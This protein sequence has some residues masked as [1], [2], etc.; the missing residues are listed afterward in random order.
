MQL[1][2]KATGGSFFEI[3]C[4][5]DGLEPDR[6]WEPAGPVWWPA[7]RLAVVRGIRSQDDVIPICGTRF[8]LGD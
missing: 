6:S 3:D 8:R 4:Q 2:P 7:R 1:H 5:T